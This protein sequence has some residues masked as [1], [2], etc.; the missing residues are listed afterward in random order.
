MIDQEMSNRDDLIPQPSQQTAG[1][2]DARH[3]LERAREV[4]AGRRYGGPRRV[5]WLLAVP[6]VLFLLVFH[7]AAQSEGAWYAFTSWD[8]LGKAKWTG[9][10]NFREI[11]ASDVARGAFWNTLKLAGGCLVVVN[12]LGLSLA[13]ALNRTVKT[14][15]A[16]RSLFFLPV[17]LSPLASAYI[18]EYIFDYHGALNRFFGAVGL[19]SWEHP[20]LGDPH[21]ALWTVFIVMVWQNSG[22]AMVIFLAGLQSIPQELDEAGAVDGAS[23]W[24]RFRRV[25]L[26]LLAPAITISATLTLIWGLRAF[27]QILALTGGGPDNATE[28]LATQ[29]YEQTWVNGL[30][31][32]GSS[33]ALVL[34]GLV[35]V[36]AVTQLMILRLREARV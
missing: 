23:A 30:F 34:T 31:G 21:W 18:W 9:L 14:R 26:P 36:L 5:P 29:V 1:W 20:W 27:D 3:A 4:L 11:W 25:T 13:L 7:F 10:A 15:H 17:V 32:Y 33:L 28:T 35:M 12:V 19:R 24:L 22:L 2:P 8:G 6:G 16:L